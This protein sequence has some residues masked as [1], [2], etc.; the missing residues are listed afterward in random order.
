MPIKAHFGGSF[1]GDLRKSLIIKDWL[2]RESNPR[3]EDFQSSALPTELP[4]RGPSR[5]LPA[6]HRASISDKNFAK[7]NMRSQLQRTGARAASTRTDTMAGRMPALRCLC[8]EA[9]FD[10]AEDVG[11]VEESDEL[12]GTRAGADGDGIL[13]G[14]DR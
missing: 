6:G 14:A 9:F 2:G 10:E 3:H 12:F 5:I 4:S 1:G 8:S 11:V 13:G 7:A